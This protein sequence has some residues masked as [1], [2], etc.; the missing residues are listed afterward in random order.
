MWKQ[1]ESIAEIQGIPSNLVITSYWII[2]SS[3]AKKKDLIKVLVVKVLI[4][5]K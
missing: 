3:I 4:A 2:V 5:R 1:G